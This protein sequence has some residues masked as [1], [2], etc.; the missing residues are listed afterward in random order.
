MQ[1][2]PQNRD[3]KKILVVDDEKSIL[4]IIE[5]TFRNEFNVTS[6]SNGAEAL[7]YLQSGEMPDLIIC[8]LVMPEIDGFDFIR[9]LRSGGY[10]EDIPLI[11]L[12]GREESGDRIR[13]FEMGADDFLVKPFNPKELLARVKRRL[14]AREKYIQR[15]GA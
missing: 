8:D 13:C 15:C 3:V 9:I 4:V 6:L 11:I 5:S 10:Y 7:T 12:S 14:S 2:T 1:E